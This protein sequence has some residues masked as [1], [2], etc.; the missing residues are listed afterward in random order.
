MD[1]LD[2][3]IDKKIVEKLSSFGYI[4]PT[5]VQQKAIPIVL[6]K[7]DVTIRSQTGSGKTFAFALPIIQQIDTRKEYVQAVVLCPT[8]ELTVQVATETKKIAEG[9][10]VRVCAVFG[11]SNIQRQIDSLKKRPHIVVGTTGRVLDLLKRGALKL[12]NADFVV[13]D[14]ADEMLDM[15]FRPD[16]ESILK[17]T[18]R[19]KQVIM[20][21]ATVPNEI[22]DLVKRYQ[23]NPV[24]VEIGEENRALDKIK[25]SYI[26]VQ[27]T[28][29]KEAL[30]ELFYSDIY[31]KTIVFCNTKIF[32]EDVAHFLKKYGVLAMALHGDLRQNERKRILENFK[33]GKT[34]VLVATDVAARG[35]DIKDIKYVINFDLPH[36]LE[37]YVHR[38]GR[39]ARAGES[40]EVI[41]IVRSLEE[42]SH[43]REIEKATNAKIEKYQTKSENLMQ[44]FVDTKKLAKQ[45]NRFAKQTNSYINKSKTGFEKRN[46]NDKS[47]SR[48][49]SSERFD[50]YLAEDKKSYK[51]RAIKHNKHNKNNFSK[52][53]KLQLSKNKRT[54]KSAKQW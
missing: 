38:I 3:K 41:N 49:S 5:E 17:H 28:K 26:F 8:R 9:M 44:Y 1:F 15:G 30:K 13:L 2:L 7:Q 37:F 11:G 4:E 45:S 34:L 33:T 32:A 48:F 35:L 23:K 47:I 36:E 20:L 25:Q 53:K 6:S 14:E 16:I 24:F 31:D 12:E 52:Q 42:M 21:S 27:R 22:K 29:K 50:F 18:K 19:D 40:G 39:T 10:E 54:Q 46:K 43:M 51:H